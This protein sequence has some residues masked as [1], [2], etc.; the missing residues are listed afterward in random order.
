MLALQRSWPGCHLRP[1]QVSGPSGGPYH[2]LQVKDHHCN[3]LG[4]RAGSF[5][6]LSLNFLTFCY[7]SLVFSLSFASKSHCS[8]ILTLM[9]IRVIFI[10]N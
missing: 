5:D 10:T 7:E 8:R 9:D 6:T 3:D 2:A 1:R 4:H